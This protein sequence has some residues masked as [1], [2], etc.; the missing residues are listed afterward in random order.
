MTWR[1]TRAQLARPLRIFII[2]GLLLALAAPLAVLADNFAQGFTAEGSLKTGTVVALSTK[3]ASAV[4]AAP[5][6]DSSLIYGVV[7][8]S[9]EAPLTLN[10]T[11]QEVF[12]ANSGT[13]PVLVNLDGGAIK[14]G[15]FISM[16]THD[17]IAA[18]ATSRQPTVLGRALAD[19][20]G[21]S[22]GKVNITVNLS[23]GRN[24]SFKNSLAIP[25]VVQKIGNAIAGH[26]VSPLRI[27]MALV[28]FVMAFIVSAISLVVG[29]RSS[30]TA[31]GRNPLSRHSILQGLIEVIM[32]SLAVFVVALIG[33]YLLL[34]L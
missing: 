4:R 28:I 2:S 18:K 25:S 13:Y 14:N 26:E 23:V 15:D 30:M 19:Y 32:A 22:S 31:I 20:S 6:S 12:V 24:P 11:G 16:S 7:V 3:S 27:Y 10:R 21:D 34:R 5:S 33:V 1:L 8:E 17:G 9:S 29:V